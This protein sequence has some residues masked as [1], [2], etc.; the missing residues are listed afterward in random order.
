MPQIVPLTAYLVWLQITAKDVVSRG[1]LHNAAAVVDEL[2][3]ALTRCKQPTCKVQLVW[4]SGAVHACS[5]RQMQQ[6]E[7]CQYSAVLHLCPLPRRSL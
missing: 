6:A 7:C 5:S 2:L 4:C 1:S 3:V